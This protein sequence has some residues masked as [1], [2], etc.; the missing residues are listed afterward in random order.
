MALRP[1][2][3]LESK[4]DVRARGLESRFRTPVKSSSTNPEDKKVVV[5]V[6]LNEIVV[7]AEHKSRPFDLA[8][9]HIASDSV[10]I[11]PAVAIDD[12]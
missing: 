7:R 6:R 8:D 3:K 2:K 10:I 1:W 5:T 9:H 11:T 12:S 4:A